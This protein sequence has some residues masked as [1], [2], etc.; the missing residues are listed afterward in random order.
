MGKSKTNYNKI[1]EEVKEEKVEV[2]EDVTEVDEEV[3]K[4]VEPVKEPEPEVIK[5]VVSNCKC[6][7]VRK[8]PST[9]TDNVI[10]IIDAGTEVTI[11]DE[12]K[13]DWYKIQTEGG[14]TGFCMKE[15]ITVK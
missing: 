8:S 5:G 9:K 7:R 14:V 1:S 6:L 10:T 3:T 12:S 15:Y 2:V 13:K 11:L 4:P